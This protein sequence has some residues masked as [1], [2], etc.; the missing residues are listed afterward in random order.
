MRK[1]EERRAN[2]APMTNLSMHIEAAFPRRATKQLARELNISERQARRI[3]ESGEAPGALRGALVSLLRSALD[4]QIR[5]A[6][7]LHDDIAAKDY[8]KMVGRSAARR[9]AV[10]YRGHGS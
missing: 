4:L 1:S 9:A 5:A 2:S 8:A 7:A 3:V 10:E 6:K